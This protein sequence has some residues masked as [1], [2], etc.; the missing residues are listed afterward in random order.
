MPDLSTGA[1]QI[2]RPLLGRVGT[3]RA[4]VHPWQ[5]AQARRGGG[6]PAYAVGLLHV[7]EGMTPSEWRAAR[8][9]VRTR[10]AQ[11]GYRLLEVFDV[12]DHAVEAH[13]TLLAVDRLV[14]ETG[15]VALVVAGPLDDVQLRDLLVRTSAELV[16]LPLDHDPD[17]P[18][19]PHTRTTNAR[20]S[21]TRE[22]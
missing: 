1:P 22:W 20:R 5:S 13:E 17:T 12:T 19:P 7:P 15:A 14:V 8:G 18:H 3:S 16:R 2:G 21:F 4:D 6:V 9:A 10:T 11:C